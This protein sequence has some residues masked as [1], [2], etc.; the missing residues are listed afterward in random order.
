MSL[1]DYESKKCFKVTWLP[2]G[3]SKEVSSAG[4]N[5]PRLAYSHTIGEC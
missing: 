5:F 1:S 4:S 2:D 3:V